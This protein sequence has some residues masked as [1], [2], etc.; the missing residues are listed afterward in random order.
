MLGCIFSTLSALAHGEAQLAAWSASALLTSLAALWL[1]HR[2][3]DLYL[4]AWR[5][6]LYAGM[7]LHR[8]VAIVAMRRCG[9]AAQRV[10]GWHG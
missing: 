2:R 1:I 7:R 9:G 3:R 10:A 4:T 6:W 8:A 5:D